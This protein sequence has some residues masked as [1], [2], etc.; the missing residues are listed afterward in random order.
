MRRYLACW[1][2]EVPRIFRMLDLIAPRAP[3]H[4]PVHLLLISAAEMGFAWDGKQQGWVR[5]ALPPLR[6]LTG[7]IQHFQS[8]IFQAWQLQS[9]AQLADREGVRGAQ[10][11]DVRGSL[12]LHIS[13]PLAGNSKKSRQGPFLCG[14]VWNVFFFGRSQG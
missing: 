5:A 7:P 4:G 6:M 11:L 10:F 1:P 12:Q 9:G 3:G 14:G 2:H 13:Y 8:A